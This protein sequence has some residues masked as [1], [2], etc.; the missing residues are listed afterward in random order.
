M[1]GG[2][3]NAINPA[4]CCATI[5]TPLASG[6]VFEESSVGFWCSKIE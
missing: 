2:F 5:F 1:P 3:S 6:K 4:G